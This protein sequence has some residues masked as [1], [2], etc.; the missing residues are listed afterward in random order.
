MATQSPGVASYLPPLSPSSRIH[1]PGFADWQVN[2]DGDNPGAIR[3]G[4]YKLMVGAQPS[5]EY[6]TGT[7]NSYSGWVAPPEFGGN[8]TPGPL[9]QICQDTPCLFDLDADPSEREDLAAKMPGM[10]QKLLKR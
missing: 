9:R 6:N 1:L 10:M 4:Q 7:Y 8:I 3:V 2:I 5:S